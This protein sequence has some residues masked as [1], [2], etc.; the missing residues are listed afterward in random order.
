MNPTRTL[1][2]LA[3]LLL[4]GCAGPSDEQAAADDPILVTSPGD[5]TYLN[6]SNALA[7]PHVHDY[8]GG[9]DRIGILD[10][11][12]QGRHELTINGDNMVWM[13][14]FLPPD[15]SVVP[16]GTAQVHLALEYAAA[17]GDRVGDLSVRYSTAASTNLSDPVA[18]QDGKV[19]LPAEDVDND[20]PHQVVSSW[21]FVV[22][23]TGE[24]GFERF[25][26]TM[27]LIVEAERGR[28]IPLYPGHPDQWNGTNEILL[29]EEDQAIY[30]LWLEPFGGCQP[31]PMMAFN[32]PVEHV[33]MDGA[34]VPTDAAYVEIRV[35]TSQE[36]PNGLQF[37]Y[38]AGD[39]RALRIVEPAESSDSERIYRI[40]VEGNGD[41]PYAK[42]SLWG[43]L[44]T[45]PSSPARTV[46]GA[47]YTITATAYRHEPMHPVP[48]SPGLQR[49]T[50]AE[51]SSA[52]QRDER[53]IIVTPG[54]GYD[55]TVA[56]KGGSLKVWL[57]LYNGG[58]RELVLE[59]PGKCDAK[60]T[61]VALIGVSTS[62]TWLLDAKC[63]V[64]AGLH[65]VHIDSGVSTFRGVLRIEGATFR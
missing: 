33:P 28:P 4:A 9:R 5:Y 52:G 34:I 8:W 51:G 35:V 24:D 60:G 47:T 7:R 17:P 49:T 30:D 29:I 54:S 38:H 65:G 41:G 40:A 26:G 21:R 43:F 13:A 1:A 42:R 6:E 59:G 23:G 64:A 22:L 36:L 19:E 37:Q 14:E 57:G 3:I 39:T 44:V 55:F 16:Q 63:D 2:A 11:T 27:R 46:E 15:G 50:M 18:F 25:K 12:W 48:F 10:E 53:E 56:S 31:F 58:S 45:G 62:G 20:L 32:C 61:F